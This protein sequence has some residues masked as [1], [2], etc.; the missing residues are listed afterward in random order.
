MIVKANCEA[1]LAITLK[2]QGFGGRKELISAFHV[3]EIVKHGI[4]WLGLTQ[5]IVIES[6][7]QA[8][9]G[10]RLAKPLRPIHYFVYLIKLNEI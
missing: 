1:K 8:T 2:F 5:K 6:S 7:L 10:K 4:T 9:M 3:W